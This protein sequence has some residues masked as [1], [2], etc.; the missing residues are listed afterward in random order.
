[1]KKYIVKSIF[2]LSLFSLLIASCTEG[3]EEINT[4]SNAPETVSDPGLLLMPIIRGLSNDNYQEAWNKANVIGDYT[5]RQFISMFGFPASDQPFW[6]FYAYQRDVYN[7]ISISEKSG[8]NNYI[9]IAL[10]LKSFM[11]QK[12]T[13]L[14]GSIPYSEAISAGEGINY[15]KYDTQQEVYNG[16]LADLEYANELLGST[17][18]PIS[19]DILYDGDITKWKMF[20]NSLRMRCLMRISDVQDPSSAMSEIVGNPIQFPLFES[21]NDQAA[22]QY[23]D[24][25]GNQFPWYQH[26]AGD[27]DRHITENFLNKLVELNDP[28]VTVYAQP[29]IASVEAGGPLEY[30]GVPNG[31]QNDDDFNGGENYQSILGLLWSPKSE[32][33]DI[34][35]PTAAQSLLMTNSELQFILAEAAEKGFISGNAATY[36][37]N[38]IKDQFN[39]YSSRIP[40]NYTMPTAASVIPSPSYYS[41]DAVAYTGSTAERLEKIWTQKWFSLFNS[42]YEG[43]FHWRRTGV[44]TITAGITTDGYVPVRMIYPLSARSANPAQ[45]DIA[46]SAQGSDLDTT[47]VWWDVN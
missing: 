11:Y 25:L 42:S 28:R 3:F 40:G 14:Y 16:I 41:Q 15:P 22:V 29:T 9:G 13:D 36:Y 20:A 46:I 24:E 45:L 31:I 32:Y 10:V 26:R 21:H 33:G 1:M 43:W 39:Y 7:V 44:P 5:E 38:G 4:N 34:A 19:G 12:L 18:E 37:M 27:Y 17:N 23:I 2:L 35:S 47:P 6:G 8:K 30:V